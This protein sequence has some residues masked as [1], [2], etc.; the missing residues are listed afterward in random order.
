MDY[1]TDE[2]NTNEEPHM[3]STSMQGTTTE[4]VVAIKDWLAEPTSVIDEPMA[5]ALRDLADEIVLAGRTK[6]LP[7]C[8]LTAERTLV[9]GFVPT[10]GEL[11][12]LG[13]KYLVHKSALESRV[14]TSDAEST[15]DSVDLEYCVTRLRILEAH[16]GRSQLELVRWFLDSRDGEVSHAVRLGDFPPN[17]LTGERRTP[18]PDFGP[19]VGELQC[20][21]QEYLSEM[22]RDDEYWIMCQTVGSNDWKYVKYYGARLDAIEVV[23]G[24]TEFTSVL[25]PVHERWRTHLRATEEEM[26][27]VREAE[28]NDANNADAEMA[29]SGS[30]NEDIGD[31]YPF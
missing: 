22:Y 11:C 6:E 28:R 21:A 16:V 13:E 10:L 4:A 3:S 1:R 27:E 26:R 30:G 7:E 15:G 25:A 5:Q 8:L 31:A 20:L 19:T 24:T 12:Y 23:L 17:Y 29:L 9:R 2:L 14:P 18:I